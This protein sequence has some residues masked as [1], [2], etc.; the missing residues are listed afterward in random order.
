MKQ[1]NEFLFKHRF[2]A[3]LYNYTEKI[4]RHKTTRF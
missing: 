3:L 1:K 2:L 4:S